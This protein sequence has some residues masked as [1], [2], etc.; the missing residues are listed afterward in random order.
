MAHARGGELGLLPRD[1]DAQ[2][3]EIWLAHFGSP[4]PV[5]GASAVAG[6]ILLEHGL[7]EALDQAGSLP[8]EKLATRYSAQALRAGRK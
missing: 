6:R 2:L 7:Q 8:E 1:E 4:M 3:A 5:Y